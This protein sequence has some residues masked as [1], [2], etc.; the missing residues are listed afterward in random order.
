[1]LRGL[2]L[3][4]RACQTDVFWAWMLLSR[5]TYTAMNKNGK[6]HHAGGG[7]LLALFSSVAMRQARARRPAHK[8][9]EAYKKQPLRA[10]HRSLPG[11]GSPG[12]SLIN[13][14]MYLATAFVS[15]YIPGVDSRDN[16]RTAQQA[17]DEYLRRSS[18]PIPPRT[19][20]Q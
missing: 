15:Q 10:G 18:T 7:P 1:V 5:E 14:R 4:N 16:L 3:S 6:T 9:V 17:I 13:A 11:R 8:G 12:S 2:R 19:E 20:G